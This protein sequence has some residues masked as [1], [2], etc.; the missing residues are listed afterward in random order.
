MQLKVKKVVIPASGL[1]TRFLTVTKSQIKE[2]LQI[3]DKPPLQY[4]SRRS[5][6]IRYR[7]NTYNNR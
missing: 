1:G 3:V 6:S 4:H 7:E 2:M 5:S